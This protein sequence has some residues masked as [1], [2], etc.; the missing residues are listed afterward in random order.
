MSGVASFVASN[1]KLVVIALWAW[2][3]S[4]GKRNKI[5]MWFLSV[6]VMLYVYRNRKDL[7]G[8]VMW[9]A[10]FVVIATWIVLLFNDRTRWAIGVAVPYGAAIGGCVWLAQNYGQHSFRQAIRLAVAER[11]S[12][13][14]ITDAVVASVGEQAKVLEVK[15]LGGGDFEAT[16]VGPA[17]MSHGELVERLRDTIAE[18][19][20]RQSGRVMRSVDVVS[21]G[22]KGRAKLRCSTTNP[23][24]QTVRLGDIL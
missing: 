1:P 5:P 12:H 20:L 8:A 13:E 10:R 21:G 11:R 17:G 18:S 3:A 19:I 6:P 9:Y 22:A 24:S 14:I 2:A 15:E 23:Y 16:V 4:W 7:P